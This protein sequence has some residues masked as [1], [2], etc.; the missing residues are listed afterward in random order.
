MQIHKNSIAIIFLGTFSF[1]I[2]FRVFPEKKR[3]KKEV[4][5]RVIYIRSE[6]EIIGF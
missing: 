3:K 2:F 5:V 6:H 1:V 4:K